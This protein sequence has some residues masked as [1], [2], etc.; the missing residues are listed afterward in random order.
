[1]IW[2]YLSWETQRKKVKKLRCLYGFLEESAV[3]C[4]VEA[5]KAL[6][7]MPYVVRKKKQLP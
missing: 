1:M 3:F 7:A 2:W 4:A 6:A 5:S